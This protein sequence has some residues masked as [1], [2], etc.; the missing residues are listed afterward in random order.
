M[1]RDPDSHSARI[2]SCVQ[3]SIS[4]AQ[5]GADWALP[6]G[7][8]ERIEKGSSGA[9]HATRPLRRWSSSTSMDAS[10]SAMRGAG[11][12]QP[13][14]QVVRLL[15]VHLRARQTGQVDRML[16]GLRH[17]NTWQLSLLEVHLR[18][19]KLGD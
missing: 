6:D 16:G 4:A 18:T 15:E 11:G 19:G 17:C 2:M 10:V 7:A 13:P 8:E 1:L 14:Q 12:D 9:A 5:A 3:P